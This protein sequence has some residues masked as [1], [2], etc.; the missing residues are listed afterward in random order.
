MMRTQTNGGRSKRVL[1]SVLVGGALLL[2]AHELDA[3]AQLSYQ[4]GQNI[5][6]AYEGWQV[7]A[8]GSR[9]FLFGYMNRN[10]EEE[11]DIPVGAENGFS[12]GPEDQG[13]PTHFLPRRNRF[14]F[15]G[16]VPDGFT[17][18]DELVWTLTANGVTETTMSTVSLGP[19]LRPV[20]MT[21]SPRKMVGRFT[22]S[23]A[24]TGG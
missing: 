3:Q 13:Q 12:P 18:Q 23:E 21:V 11:L 19:K 24:S 5:S 16:P 1:A 8:D 2:A 15:R 20:R 22:V 9:Y 4:R 7:D 14:V 17:E 10:W 6:P